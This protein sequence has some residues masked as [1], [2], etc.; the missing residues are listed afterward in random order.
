MCTVPALINTN[1][2]QA[3]TTWK[4]AGFT[5]GNL[6]FSPLIPPNGKI[7]TQSLNGGTSW[8][9]TSTMTVTH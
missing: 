3:T 4:A 8:L 5:A 9:C 6:L 7:L 1:T 2:S